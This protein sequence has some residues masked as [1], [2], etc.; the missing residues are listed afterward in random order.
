LEG[1][2]ID[3]YIIEDGIF[4]KRYRVQ[5]QTQQASFLPLFFFQSVTTVEDNEYENAR[6]DKQE[7]RSSVSLFGNHGA[8]KIKATNEKSIVETSYHLPKHYI[9]SMSGHNANINMFKDNFRNIDFVFGIKNITI[10]LQQIRQ[11]LLNQ[12]HK[13]VT[14]SFGDI[15]YKFHKRYYEINIKEF[16]HPKLPL[17]NLF[18]SIKPFIKEL[19]FFVKRPMFSYQDESRIVLEIKNEKNENIYIHDLNKKRLE[20]EV[21]KSLFSKIDINEY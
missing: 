16:N 21:S 7:G 18:M 4:T 5:A 1:K 19:N 13:N 15:S 3:G 11:G 8:I 6:G 17:K 2:F 12:G 9:L 20:I 10:L 14:I